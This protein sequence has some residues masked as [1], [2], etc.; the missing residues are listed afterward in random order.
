M[1]NLTFTPVS[2]PAVGVIHSPFKE[3]FGIPRQPGLLP[4]VP[5]TLE[6]LP[7]YDNPDCVR[8]LEGFSHLW[9]I[10]HFH[11][12]PAGQWQPLVRPPRL[13]GNARIGVF[14][15]R[16]THRPNPLG[17]SVV[18]LEKVETTAGVR[19]HIQGADLLD[20]TP[21]F[22]IKPYLPYADAIDTA[23]AAYAAEPP[24]VRLQVVF[25]EVAW[26][27]CERYRQQ[28]GMDLALLIRRMLE[29]DPRPAYHADSRR[30]YGF[31]LADY[32]VRWVVDGEQV[33]VEDLI[34][35]SAG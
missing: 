9:L 34:P 11:A 28:T 2:L 15:S 6:L 17:L 29:L 18:R 19:L 21:V 5:A 16:S 13:G 26:H 1:A 24:E 31:R 10:F 7:P 27:I 12:V 3:K 33:T 25:S 23:A 30:Q 14:A 32:D 4:E 20:G 22:D 8:G 35:V